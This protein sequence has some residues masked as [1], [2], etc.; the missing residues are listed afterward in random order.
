MS[1]TRHQDMDLWF[2]WWMWRGSEANGNGVERKTLEHSSEAIESI[3]FAMDAK[4]M[5]PVGRYK[6]AKL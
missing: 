6:L 5:E 1:H 4:E 2:F 3:G